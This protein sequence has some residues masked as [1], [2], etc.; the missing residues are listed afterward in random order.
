MKSKQRK[1]KTPKKTETNRT[2][3]GCK[4][5]MEAHRGSYMEDSSLI[6]GPS[7]LPCQFG[8]VSVRQPGF[9][10][11]KTGGA[12]DLWRGQSLSLDP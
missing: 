12:A 10:G 3:N 6:R 8:V 2:S 11:L 4:I 1:P 7:P 5:N 9:S